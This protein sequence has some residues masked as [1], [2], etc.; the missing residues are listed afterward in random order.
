MESRYPAGRA[1][2]AERL[3]IP[4]PARTLPL[5]RLHAWNATAYQ[6]VNPGIFHW[7]SD[8]GDAV[9]GFVRCGRFCVVAGAP[10]CAPERLPSV[11]EEW[12][13]FVH[14]QGCRSCFFGAAGRLHALLDGTAGYATVVL[15]AQPVWDPRAWPPLERLRPSLRSQLRRAHNK[16]VVVTEWSS[17]RAHCHPELAR[18]LREWLDRKPLPSLRFLVEPDTLGALT[19]K[20]LFVAERHG[21]PIGFVNAAPIPARNGWLSEQF[22]RG[23]DAPNGTAELMLDTTVRALAAS[24]AAYFTMGLVPLASTNWAPREY[25]P[26]WL[27]GLLSWIRAHGNRFYHFAGLEAFKTKFAPNSWEPIYAI[28]EETDFSPSALWA[29]A[30]AFCAGSPL[31][32][33]GRGLGRALRQEWRWLWNRAPTRR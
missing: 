12:R 4:D 30:T 29:I 14:A 27:R 5:L 28:S 25:N 23:A 21:R 1:F 9:I 31:G 20:R 18:V 15:G 6:I 11:L 24:G 3:V 8:A 32:L 19:D 16:G 22:V 17:E 7:F 26:V 13:G 2:P 10:V 33:L